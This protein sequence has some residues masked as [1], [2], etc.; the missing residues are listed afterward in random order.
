MAMVWWMSGVVDVCVVDIVQSFHMK[1]GKVYDMY[2]PN[3]ILFRKNRNIFSEN[4]SVLERGGFPK[5]YTTPDIHHTMGKIGH[6]PHQTFTT[7]DIHHTMGKRGHPP[8]QTWWGMSFDSKIIGFNLR[9]GI[10]GF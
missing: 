1:S 4:L 8:H 9:V 5:T 3:K 2:P 10:S 6:P 7:P